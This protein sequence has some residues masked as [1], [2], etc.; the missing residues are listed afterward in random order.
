LPE[1]R[2][3]GF[4]INVTPLLDDEYLCRKYDGRSTLGAIARAYT[5]RAIAV[6]PRRHAA[7]VVWIEKELWP[8]A[9]AWLE[10]F[11]WGRRPVMLDFDDAV[12]HS[13]DLHRSPAARALFGDKI[14]QLMRAATLVVVGND[15]LARR[16]RQAG[17][18]R[19]E[20]LPTV[21]DLKR[22]VVA[23]RETVTDAP[24]RVGWIGS[25]ATVDYVRQLAGPLAALAAKRRVVL[26]LIGAKVNLPNVPI[27]FVPWTES[28]EVQAIADLD[29][30]VMPLPDSPWERGK[31]GYKLVQYL[32]CGVPVVASPVGVNATLVQ[33]GE[34]G[35]LATTDAEWIQ[36]LTCLADDEALRR[37]LGAQGRALVESRYSLQVA[38][39]ILAAWLNEL[40]GMR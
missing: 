32:A 20:V 11:A 19:V 39:P 34:N 35:F 15:Y 17:A 25:P 16:A 40:G 36:A 5:R 1:L 26:R 7:D 13:Y 3:L 2:R 30:G 8:W 27:E 18:Q 6:L 9:P 33:P 14:D 37:R 38:A 31:C 21:V 24:L 4:D 12:F 10:R 28:G 22:Y 23:T 29:V